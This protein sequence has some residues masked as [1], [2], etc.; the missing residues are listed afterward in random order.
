MDDNRVVAVLFTIQL[1]LEKYA[2]EYILVNKTGKY[3]RRKY[4]LTLK[5]WWYQKDWYQEKSE[6]KYI[7]TGILN[8]WYYKNKNILTVP[9]IF[10]PKDI[11]KIYLEVERN[12][13][14]G[15]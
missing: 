1:M 3:T 5:D 14:H 10:E 13:N 2:I 7:E 15:W 4:N 12:Y 9:N 11:Q 8:G 6:F